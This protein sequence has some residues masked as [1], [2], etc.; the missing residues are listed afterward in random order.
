MWQ[1]KW[2]IFLQLAG[3]PAD[4]S[5]V[6]IAWKLYLLGVTLVAGAYLILDATSLSKLVLYNGIGLSAVVAVL[7]G[8]KIHRPEHETAWFVVAAAMATFLA[9]DVVYY[10]LE[11][12]S[13]SVPYPSVADALYLSMYPIMIVG[14]TMML[15]RISPGR[16]TA[17]IIDA[18]LVAVATFAVLG[19][20]VM[21]EYFHGNSGTLMSRL[22]SMAYPVMDV[23]LIMVAVRVVSAV[24]LRHRTFAFMTAGL[25][26]LLVADTMYGIVNTA[27]GYTTGGII[28]AFW[29]GFYSLIG[30]GALHPSMGEHIE[31]R[32][33]QQGSITRPRLAALFLVVLAVPVIDLV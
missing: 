16:D 15:R 31:A 30:A 7:V 22:I 28:D 9:A 6:K 32:E 5:A 21:D 2:L 1:T 17:G 26:S 23:A 4:S 8:I 14:L 25:S 12:T 13:D 18:T 19:I 33:I 11:I 20:L 27:A 24:H 29:I 10:V 3:V